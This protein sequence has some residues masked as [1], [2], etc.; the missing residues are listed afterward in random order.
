MHISQTR[1]NRYISEGTIGNI[2]IFITHKLSVIVFWLIMKK[3]AMNTVK[4][5][6]DLPQALLFDPNHS[7][8]ALLAAKIRRPIKGGKA[9]RR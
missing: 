3:T 8:R 5:L 2:V 6:E 9:Q 4:F 7:F 1:Y